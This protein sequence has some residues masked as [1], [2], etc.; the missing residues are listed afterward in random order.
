M[1]IAQLFAFVT[2]PILTRVLTKEQYG[3]LGL[4]TTT[5]LFAVAIAKA[6]LSDGVIRFYKE[7][8]AAREKLETF[9]STILIRGMIFSG[10]VSLFYLIFLLLIRKYLRINEG[11]IICFL[12]MALYLF[13]RP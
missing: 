10:L 2:F 12:I 13:I 11:Y 7:Y 6:G 1:V 3:I 8:S 4:V 9:S 5:M